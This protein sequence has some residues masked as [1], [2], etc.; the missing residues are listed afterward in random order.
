MTGGRQ[1]FLFGRALRPGAAHC[2]SCER[3]IGPVRECPYC[4]EASVHN[5][6]IHKLRVAV[7]L[8]AIFGLAGLHGFA[9]NTEPPLV[10]IS[11]INSMMG[12]AR[13]RIKGEVRYDAYVGRRSGDVSYLSFLVSDGTGRARLVAYGTVARGILSG[14]LPIRGDVISATVAVDPRSGEEPRLRLDA[15]NHLVLSVG[16][17]G[18]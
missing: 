16:R 3:F 2:I 1:P 11:A 14:Y 15:P 12:F 13:V 8:L 17:P 9:A 10:E 5:A 18:Q 6:F 4:S 7:V